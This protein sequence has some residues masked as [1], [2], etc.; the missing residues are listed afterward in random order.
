MFNLCK[1]GYFDMQAYSDFSNDKLHNQAYSESEGGDG[2]R[3]AAG[4]L[5]GLLAAAHQPL[6]GMAPRKVFNWRF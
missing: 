6:S 5:T 1:Q 4:G 2:T 3:R